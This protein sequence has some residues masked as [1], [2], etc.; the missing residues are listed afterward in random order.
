[1]TGSLKF[2]LVGVTVLAVAAVWLVTLAFS[3]VQARQEVAE[4]LDGHLAQAASVLVA[5][6]GH[7]LEEVETEHAPLLHKYARRVAFQVFDEHGRLSLHSLNAPNTPLAADTEGFSDNTI[8][9]ERWRVFSA[10]VDGMMVHVGERAQAREGLARELVAGMIK[11]LLLAIPALALVL[12]I[13][14]GR[15]LSPLSRIASEV[16]TRAPDNLAPLALE[17]MPAEVQPLAERLNELFARLTRSLDSERR[18]T[19]DAAH[20]LRTPLAGIRAQ[21]QVALGASDAQERQRALSLVLLGCDR[22]TRLVEQL[23]TLS[24]IEHAPAANAA[25]VALRALAA[26]V[27]G[28]AAESAIRKGIDLSLAEGDEHFIAGQGDLL[29]I[30][31][32]NL[33]DNAIRYTPKGGRVEVSLQTEVG[34]TVLRVCDSGPGIAPEERSRVLQRFYRVLGSGEEGSGLGLS[35]VSRIAD[36]HH[37]S[38]RLDEASGGGLRVSL[39][40][41]RT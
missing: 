36:L 24:R 38:I 40:F 31:L 27:I 35:I 17:A 15:G 22:A 23:L 2:R 4:M 20:E 34:D 41:G 18:F 14:V 3:Y 30:L 33:V 10:R 39:H 32:R 21:A 26:S 19:A 25:D 13:G 6:A 1:M 29:R 5:Q 9:G 16:A 8:D 37:A 7:E 12:W 28:E 11:P